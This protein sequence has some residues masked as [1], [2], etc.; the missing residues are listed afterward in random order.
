MQPFPSSD[1]SART[2]AFLRDEL[3]IS[4]AAIAMAARQTQVE[5]AELLPVALW[6][7]GLIS[8]GQLQ[9]IFDWFERF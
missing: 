7:Y 8:L 3:A 1:R 2:I 6:M 4:D 5:A 9:Q